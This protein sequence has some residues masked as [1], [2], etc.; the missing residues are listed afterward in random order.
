MIGT[1]VNV[2]TIITGSLIGGI[3][4]KVLKE[5]YSKLVARK[6]FIM[7]PKMLLLQIL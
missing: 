1:L 6:I 2:G 4:K 7:N 3:V 5:E